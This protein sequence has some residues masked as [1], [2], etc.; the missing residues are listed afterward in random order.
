MTEPWNFS[1]NY[2]F[3]LTDEVQEEL[4]IE[5]TEEVMVVNIV[6]V[7]DDPQE[8][9]MNLKAPI[10][11]NKDKR[12]AKQIILEEEAYPVKHRLFDAKEEV[13]C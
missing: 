4:N 2:E 6:V 1:S 8:M 7:P 11:I 5:S 3:D 10:I 12:L 9:T 13:K